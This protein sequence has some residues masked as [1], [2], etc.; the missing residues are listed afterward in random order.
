M[1]G[2][3]YRPFSLVTF[4]IEHQIAEG[5][6][7]FISHLINILLYSLLCFILYKLLI[8]IQEWL[9]QRNHPLQVAFFSTLLFAVHPIHTEV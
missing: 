7:P 1:E 8:A 5:D 6:N 4:A 9:G 2:G 3:R